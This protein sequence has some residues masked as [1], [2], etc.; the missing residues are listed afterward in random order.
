[1]TKSLD[2]LRRDARALKTAFEAGDRH[3]RE[4]LRLR[5]P[6]PKGSPLKHADYLHVIAQENSFASW[7]DLK[8][9]VELH[10]M[11]RATKL[12]RL[13]VALYNGQMAVVE[14]LLDEVPDLADGVLGLE[15]ALY[16]RE[17][18]ETALHVD[19]TC[20]DRDLGP[21]P[22]FVHLA[23][24]RVIH[25]HPEREGDMLAIAELLLSLMVAM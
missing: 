14:R 23:R 25:A 6:R 13:K 16:R 21:A 11:D 15:I 22:A 18:V 4:R 24:S 5:P 12:Q 2:Q 8:L 20:L 7:P 19:P 10:G 9:T 17:A 3:A 1:M